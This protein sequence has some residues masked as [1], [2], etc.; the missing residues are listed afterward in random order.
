MKLPQLRVKHLKYVANHFF[1]L[2]IISSTIFVLVYPTLRKN[3]YIFTL[4]IKKIHK[5]CI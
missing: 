2:N 5:N 3:L 1:L 4:M